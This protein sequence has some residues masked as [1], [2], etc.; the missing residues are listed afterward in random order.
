MVKVTKVTKAP[1]KAA[2]RSARTCRK[3]APDG[4]ALIEK[5]EGLAL[6]PGKKRKA[7]SGDVSPAKKAK[8]ETEDFSVFV[9]NLMSG[10]SQKEFR[11]AVL[12]LLSKHGLEVQDLVLN[13]VKRRAYVSLT[14]EEHLKK[15]LDLN[16]L[17]VLGRE[18][19]V[20]KAKKDV[21]RSGKRESDQ[22][23]LFLRE[24]PCSAKKEDLKEVFCQAVD[25]RIPKS[26][27][28]AP[29]GIAYL[30]FETE[31]VA[32]KVMAEKQGAEVKGCPVV[33][34]WTGQKRALSQQTLVV[35][36]LPSDVT[37]DT[38][39]G[40]FEKAVAVRLPKIKGALRGFAFV[41]FGSSEDAKEAM[42]RLNNTE[43]NGSLIVIEMSS[44]AR[45]GK[46]NPDVDLK[47]LC[48]KGL[49]EKTTTKVLKEAFQ[50]CI[51]ARVVMSKESSKRFGFVAFSNE[52]A[53]RKAK[54]AM[55]HC[56]I[57]GSKVV[58]DYAMLT[59]KRGCR[60]TF[61]HKGEQGG[62]KELQQGKDFKAQGKTRR[63]KAKLDS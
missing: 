38:L 23:T 28:D 22:R 37:K 55:A 51:S 21:F 25:I 10:N 30:E 44:K 56:E 39:K 45:P 9:G 3:T 57:D 19:R 42:E 33:L 27:S 49:S 11:K 7:E 58:L 2:A 6:M 36:N 15:A 62:D 4:G 60:K 5:D 63:K 52:K 59:D 54:R 24:V 46:E 48:V 29:R 47:S 41:D 12:N 18:L 61:G 50:G 20:E 32:E 14:C 26:L 35:K 34:E 13:R 53:C 17:N 16:G 8:P 31:A 1:L 43:I 40:T